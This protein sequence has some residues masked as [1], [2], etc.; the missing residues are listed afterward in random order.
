MSKIT[1]D[2]ID[3][4]CKNCQLVEK[5]LVFGEGCVVKDV[6]GNEY[7]D[8]CSQTLNL[9]LGQCNDDISKRVKEQINKLTFASSR[10]GSDVQLELAKEIISITP[11]SLNKIN[12]KNTSGS[13]ANENAIKAARKKH[14]KQRVISLYHSHH[15]QTHE[16]MRISGKN[17][18][19]EYLDKSDVFFGDLPYCFRC[20]YGLNSDSCSLECMESLYSNIELFKNEFSCLIIEPVMFDAGVIIPPKKYHEKIREFCNLCDIALIYDEVQ[21]GFGWLG[22]F[23]ATDYYGVTPDILTMGKAMGA[24][25]P[26]AACLMKQEYDVLTYGEHEITYGAHPVSLAATIENISYLKRAGLKLAKDAS[27]YSHQKF[28]DLKKAH[29]CIGDVRSIGLLSGIEFC[30]CDNNPDSDL[31]KE[32]YRLSLEKGVLFR[33]SKVGANSN[34]LQFKPP[35]IISRHEIDKAIDT[36]DSVISSLKI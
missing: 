3:F 27:I 10:F 36:L 26:I 6:D 25:F 16:M 23:F 22:T 19:K 32:V 31:A 2:R 15:G 20:K 5:S 34:I 1:D 18:D 29:S 13:C 33:I 28:S 30:D 35:I 4:L 9:S 8:C 7:L 11:D 12:F 24:G 17:F 21:T 14:G